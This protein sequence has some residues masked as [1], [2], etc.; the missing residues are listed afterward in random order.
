MNERIRK[1]RKQLNLTMEKFG[2]K[3]GVKKNTV[4]QWESGAN[5]LTDQMFKSICREFNV[6][7]EWLRNGTGE[8]LKP[9]P[10][11]ELDMLAYKY[12]LSEADYVMI[13]KFVSLRPE[14]RQAVFNYMKDVVASF[15][16]S[17]VEPFSPA[18]GNKPPQ[19]MDD[20]LIT[21]N[22]TGARHK[23][24]IDEQVEDFR[25]QLEAEEKAAEGSS[26]L[27]RDA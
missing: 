3:L 21:K 11:D 7:E 12:H 22:E 9:A 8:M 14:T 27:R 26:A 16:G 5:S 20:V 18:Y 17:G 10:S 23:P 13:E 4:S 15:E 25:R 1:L 19:P 24:S 2:Q 6:N